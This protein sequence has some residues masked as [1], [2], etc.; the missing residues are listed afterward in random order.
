M[1]TFLYY[2]S[3]LLFYSHESMSMFVL[4]LLNLWSI[5]ICQWDIEFSR[6]TFDLANTDS[7]PLDVT[8][9]DLRMVIVLYAF[10][11][12]CSFVQC[13][14]LCSLGVRGSCPYP[15]LFDTSIFCSFIYA[16]CMAI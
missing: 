14:S 2:V 9:Y 6:C 11:R 8:D 7:S 4:S 5:K 16:S 10:S 15:S 3:V 13:V 1:I 12:I